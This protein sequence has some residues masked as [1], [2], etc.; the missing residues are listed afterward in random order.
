MGGNYFLSDAIFLKGRK[1]V[2]T[3]NATVQHLRQ[4]KAQDETAARRLR[5]VFGTL[6]LRS[7][8]SRAH[9]NGNGVQKQHIRESTKG[10]GETAAKRKVQN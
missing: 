9:P 1:N 4:T 2:V 6:L 3:L 5:G 10:L 7:A 8:I